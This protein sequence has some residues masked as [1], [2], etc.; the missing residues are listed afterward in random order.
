MTGTETQFGQA[1]YESFAE[2]FPDSAEPWSDLDS[3]LQADWHRA[4]Q[5]A[6]TAYDAMLQGKAD[7]YAEQV[8]QAPSFDQHLGAALAAAA[9]AGLP[10]V[11]PDDYADHGGDDLDAGADQA[12]E[13][14]LREI[15][16][17]NGEPIDQA[18]DETPAEPAAEPAQDE[19]SRPVRAYTT[20]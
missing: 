4:A 1:A 6:I 16:L 14:R 17:N 8:A 20:Y 10:V 12:A 11:A 19:P 2:T 3:N 13:D 7:A 5:A 15:E 9:A 18:P